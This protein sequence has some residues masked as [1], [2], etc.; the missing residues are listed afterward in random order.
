M[1][2]K[3]LAFIVVASLA[4][5]ATTTDAAPIIRD[6]CNQTSG[7]GQGHTCPGSDDL[8]LR[9]KY[10]DGTCGD[11]MCC[12]PN[13]DGRTYDCSNPKNPTRAAIGV[14][15]GLRIQSIDV[16]T[17]L[18][19]AKPPFFPGSKPQIMSPVGTSKP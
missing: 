7:D 19:P 14:L 12:A 16:D 15:K 6:M 17:D 4:G 1:R 2:S 11:W 18:G 8:L 5:I 3:L 9:P 10:E 13:A